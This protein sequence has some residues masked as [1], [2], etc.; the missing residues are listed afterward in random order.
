MAIASAVQRGAFVY[1]Y[2]ERGRL[3]TTLAAGTGPRDGLQGY[4]GGTVAIRRGAFVYVYDERGQLRSTVA[5][6]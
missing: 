5:S 6:R 3:L 4:T 2:D 1:V